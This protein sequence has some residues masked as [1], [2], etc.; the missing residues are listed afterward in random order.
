MAHEIKVPA[1][2]ESIVEATISRWLKQAGEPV[3]VGEVLLE[4]ETDKVN[5]EVAAEY[6]GAL[7]NISKNEGDT[8]SIGEVLG[9]IGAG[10]A[11]SA[12]AVSSAPPVAAAP[13]AAE[14]PGNGVGS[15]IATPVAQTVAAEYKVDLRDISGSGPGGRVTKE[16]V[17]RHVGVEPAPAAKST[18]PAPQ[19]QPQPAAPT[20]K[21]APRNASA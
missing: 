20:A 18:P 12:A 6:G 15:A 5:L 19:P 13:V 17:L 2:G 4:L 11:S 9:E 14:A 7:L 3:A 8:V 1:L 16:D 21:P 10:E